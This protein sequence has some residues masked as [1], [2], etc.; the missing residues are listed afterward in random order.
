M[1]IIYLIK[2]ISDLGD[3]SYKIGITGRNP[4]QRLKELQT[5]T[6]QELKVISTFKSKYGTLLESA[7]HTHYEHIR[8]EW[9]NISNEEVHNFLEVCSKIENNLKI[10]HEENTYFQQKRNKFL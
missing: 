3:I 2:A 8:G 10:I 5:G 4:E 6:S 9:F 7:L 1:K